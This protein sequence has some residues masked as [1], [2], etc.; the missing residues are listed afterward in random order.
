MEAVIVAGIHQDIP[1]NK[2]TPRALVKIE[3]KTIIERQIHSLYVC[4]VKRVTI[5]TGES[6]EKI[7]DH[8]K[9][10]SFEGVSIRCMNNPQYETT[11]SA[12]SFLYGLLGID[13]DVIFLDDGVI[14]ETRAIHSMEKA[15]RHT[16]LAIRKTHM[17]EEGFFVTVQNQYV[18]EIQNNRADDV[19][20][21]VG[22][23]KIPQT[24]LLDLRC[25]LHTL[26]K[27]PSQQGIDFAEAIQ[28]VMIHQK[29]VE[30]IDFSSFAGGPIRTRKDLKHI[31]NLWKSQ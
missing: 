3:N 15:I 6:G 4:G 30:W 7:Q 23:A 26:M 1:V 27:S 9:R 29:K 5:V 22:V 16:T 2:T 28:S 10:L 20:E 18:A 11:G 21:F 14:Y 17:A 8:V 31:R 25:K 24:S 19:C 13:D 12:F